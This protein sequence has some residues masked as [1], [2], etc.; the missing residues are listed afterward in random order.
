M[1]SPT[2]HELIRGPESLVDKIDTLPT[3]DIE[4]IQTILRCHLQYCLRTLCHYLD[5]MIEALS[6]N[7]LSRNTWYTNLRN[8]ASSSG[9]YALI[10]EEVCNI[11]SGIADSNSNGYAPTEHVT[12]IETHTLRVVRK[13]NFFCGGRATLPLPPIG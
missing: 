11:L 2:G 13:K 10:L 5:L 6:Q 12:V 1:S 3:F 9:A 4:K 8:P 7:P